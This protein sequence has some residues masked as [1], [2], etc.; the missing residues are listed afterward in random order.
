MSPPVIHVSVLVLVVVLT[1]AVS[2]HWFVR[3][4]VARALSALA[5][6]LVCAGLAASLGIHQCY[7]GSPVQQWLLPSS[8]IAI[9]LTCVT[10]RA[11]RLAAAIGLA[12]AAAL[13]SADFAGKVHEPEYVGRAEPPKDS[14][15]SVGIPEWFTPL[16]GFYR[17]AESVQQSR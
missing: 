9:V 7:E 17:R 8:C 6:A 5:I 10:H 3:P 11:V 15:G 4:T 16:T 14:G 1:V 2:K 13:L 12:L